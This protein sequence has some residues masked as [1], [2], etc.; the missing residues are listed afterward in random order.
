[1]VQEV[2]THKIYQYFTEGGFVEKD[3]LIINEHSFELLIDGEY[4]ATYNCTPSLLEELIIGNLVINKLINHVADLTFEEINK[5]YIKTR[6]HKQTGL[7]YKVPDVDMR[8]RA[9]Q[10]LALMDKHLDSSPLHKSTGGTHVMSLANNDEII[11]SCQDIGRHNALDKLYGYCLKNNIDLSDKILFSSGRITKEICLKLINIGIKIMVSRA[12]VSSMAIE[13][14]HRH[15]LTLIGFARGNRF[16][17][18]THPYRIL[19]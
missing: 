6:L 8:I 16:N 14:A 3:D 5:N 7:E 19:E 12:T 11:F 13:L 18:Y 17:L 9:G 4:H 2:S 10:I 15:N 1:M